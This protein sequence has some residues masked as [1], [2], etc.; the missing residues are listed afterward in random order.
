M[1]TLRT[2]RP[3]SD[4]FDRVNTFSLQVKGFRGPKVIWC[5]LRQGF[6]TAD[7]G[8]FWV[9][10]HAGVIADSYTEAEVAE[11]NRLNS[12]TPVKDGD[13]VLVGGCEYQVKVNGDYSDAA[14]LEPVNFPIAV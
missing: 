14:I 4:N 12:E 10:Q 6:Q 11:R 1:N 13:I 2:L 3:V 5:S 7:D 8:I 9:M